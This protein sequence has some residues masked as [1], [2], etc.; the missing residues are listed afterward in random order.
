MDPLGYGKQEKTP[1]SF[2]NIPFIDT[3]D[4]FKIAL[5]GA[6]DTFSSIPVNV[7]KI[8]GI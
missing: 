4:A 2:M 1:Q 5:F 6:G 8:M 7:G 3:Y